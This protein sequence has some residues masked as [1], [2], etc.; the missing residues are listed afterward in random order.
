MIFCTTFNIN[1]GS[2]KKCIRMFKSPILP[3]GIK[4]REFLW[5]FGVPDALIVFES[6]DEETAGEFVIQF[7]D[8]AEV[9]TSVVFPVE[10]LRW[11][12]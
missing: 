11:V 8:L 3:E 10:K 1:P 2:Y 7:G 5:M 9:K 6:P 4:I 12:P